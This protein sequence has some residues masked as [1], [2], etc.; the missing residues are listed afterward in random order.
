ML[1]IVQVP[2]GQGRYL[3]SHATTHSTKFLSDV[4][5]KR[6]PQYK[7]PSGEDA[8]VQTVIDNS[9][10]QRELGLQFTP[11]EQTYID[12][13]TTLIQEGIAKPVPK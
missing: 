12:F 11:V 8:P 6:F 1:V 2:G 3:V 7:F 9:K 13:A 5:S 10:V 4:L